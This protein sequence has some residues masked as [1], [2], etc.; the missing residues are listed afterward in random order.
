[1]PRHKVEYNFDGKLALTTAMEQAE[2][3]ELNDLLSRLIETE[4]NEDGREFESVAEEL[5][6]LAKKVKAR[7]WK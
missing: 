7:V 3:R 4:E 6:L 2:L 5:V 1:M